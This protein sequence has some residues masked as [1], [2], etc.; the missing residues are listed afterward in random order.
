M[1][2]C[3]LEGERIIDRDKLHVILAAKLQFPGWYGRNLDALYD[4]LKKSGRRRRFGFC[5][6]RL[7]NGIWANITDYC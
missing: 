2:I 7:W 6:A 5:R 3:S 1:K 4:C